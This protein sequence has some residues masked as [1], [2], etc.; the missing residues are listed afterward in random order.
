MRGGGAAG[1]WETAAGAGATLAR[2]AGLADAGATAGPAGEGAAPSRRIGV[3][4]AMAITGL[5]RRTV[6]RRVDAWIDYERAETPYA[7]R[8]DYA[9]RG[10]RAGSSRYVSR[11]DAEALAR[12]MDGLEAPGRH[13]RAAE[14]GGGQ[15]DGDTANAA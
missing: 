10:W 5:P 12:Q 8:S 15:P 1:Q 6:Q 13:Q 3:K 4:E 11:D 7:E 9:L 14:A 2:M